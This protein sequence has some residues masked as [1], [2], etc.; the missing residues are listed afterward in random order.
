[1]KTRLYVFIGT[2]VAMTIGMVIVFSHSALANARISKGSPLASGPTSPAAS[3]DCAALPAN[4]DAVVAAQLSA[5][6]LHRYGL[7]DIHTNL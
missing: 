3:S 5:A 6:E 2:V 1:M 7:V 4:I